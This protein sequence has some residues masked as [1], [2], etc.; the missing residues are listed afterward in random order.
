MIHGE[1][2]PQCSICYVMKSFNQPCQVFWLL[3]SL[4]KAAILI[5]INGHFT[6]S[7]SS[8]VRLYPDKPWTGTTKLMPVIQAPSLQ[9]GQSLSLGKFQKDCNGQRHDYHSFDQLSLVLRRCREAEKI[10]S[11]VEEN[12]LKWTAQ[13]HYNTQ[14][15]GGGWART[16]SYRFRKNFW[17]S[18]F[19][20]LCRQ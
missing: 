16:V 4:S 19:S 17:S 2:L 9:T 11:K 20:G 13:K 5:V 1:L 8:I 7:E 18:D 3:C 12:L 14:A 6:L 10:N 15:G